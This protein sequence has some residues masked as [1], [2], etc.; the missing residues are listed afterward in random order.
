MLAPLA[1]FMI[2]TVGGVVSGTMM[3]LTLTEMEDVPILPAESKALT[4]RV[5]L[6]LANAAEFQ[7]KAKGEADPVAT[8]WV[9]TRNWTLGMA[10]LDVAPPCTEI[11]PEIVEELAG[12]EIETT[13][14]GTE[15]TPC[16]AVTALY[17]FT[18]P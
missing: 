17:A 8:C 15:I 11:V 13:G 3:L 14:G 4:V 7:E 9:S 18:R 6:P 5:W 12:L 2:A 16:A 10:K 1:G